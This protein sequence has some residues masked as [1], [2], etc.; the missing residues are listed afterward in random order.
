MTHRLSRLSGGATAAGLAVMINACAVDAPPLTEP[1][2]IVTAGVDGDSIV[3]AD[4]ASPNVREMNG[5]R[6]VRLWETGPLPIPL[7]FS[8]DAGATAGN[9]YREG[10]VG[11]SLYVADIPPGSN[12]DDIPLHAQDSLDYI[13]VLAGEID[14]VTPN[15]TR[16]MKAGDIL[17]QVGTMHSW[18]NPTSD[19]CRLLVVVLTGQRA[20]RP[21]LPADD[22]G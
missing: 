6:I 19:Y 8:G 21:A 10:F 22:S 18:V 15:D 1:R 12:L 17:V 20:D 16:R 13:A 7:E 3:V 2:R 5:S 4:G 14:L 11:S 9:A